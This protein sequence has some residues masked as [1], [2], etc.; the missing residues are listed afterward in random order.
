MSITPLY[1]RLV[2]SSY[3]AANNPR[4]KLQTDRCNDQE[5]SKRIRLGGGGGNRS[6]S[7]FPVCTS[8][9]INTPTTIAPR[10]HNP[11]SEPETP[12]LLPAATPF[13]EQ[14]TSDTQQPKT[15]AQHIL[16]PIPLNQSHP[17]SASSSRSPPLS[18]LSVWLDSRLRVLW[19]WLAKT[20][21]E[22]KQNPALLPTIT[23]L[24]HMRLE[25]WDTCLPYLTCVEMVELIQRKGHIRSCVYDDLHQVWELEEDER[26][27][28]L[29]PIHDQN[30][31]DWFVLVRTRGQILF[32]SPSEL[33]TPDWLSRDM[34]SL[35]AAPAS[36]ASASIVSKAT[37]D[38]HYAGTPAGQDRAEFY[39]WPVLM[40]R[41][42]DVDVASSDRTI[43]EFEQKRRGLILL[44]LAIQLTTPKSN[45]AKWTL[46]GE[47]ANTV[48]V[49][50]PT[51]PKMTLRSLK[52]WSLIH[53]M[54]P[55]LP[56]AL[57]S[58][59]VREWNNRTGALFLTFVDSLLQSSGKR[60]E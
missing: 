13:V 20:D 30:A 3:S 55:S 36:L 53:L 23:V 59:E 21:P 40:D 44:A 10:N 11:G 19:K 34:N 38:C 51:P 28:T 33:D 27:V 37:K 18:S 60:K 43:Q 56:K 4:S 1:G 6:V 58:K 45:P 48:R 15:H 47:T 9:S 39:S 22:F 32:W 14:K 31:D 57:S 8:P 41:P 24:P 46:C 54:H 26:S 25:E 29:L 52:E 12:V 5:A 49:T 35:N 50:P 17:S 16:P 2:S 42:G 7:W